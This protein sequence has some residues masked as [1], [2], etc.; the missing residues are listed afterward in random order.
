VDKPFVVI[1]C[2]AYPET[3]LESELFGHEKG[4]FTGANR[5][6]IGRFEQ[7][8]SGTVFLD[9]VGE[10]SLSA[11]VKLLRVLQTQELERLGGEQTIKVD[12]RIL[13]A[14]NKELLEEVNNGNFREDL[15]YRLNVIPIQLPPLR[16]RR[17]DIPLLARHFQRKFASEHGEAEK[18]FNPEVMYRLLNYHWAGNVRELENA[19][20]HAVVLSKDGHIDLSHLPF[21]LFDVDVSTLPSETT[22]SSVARTIVDTEKKLLI[23]VLEECKW[24]KT[25]AAQQLGISRSTLYD[26]IKKYQI[27][28]T[29]I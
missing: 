3:L 10:I 26:K 8:D 15:Y 9:E 24:N 19:I 20:E 18:D 2:S 23:D 17:N 29:D 14:T 5:Q 25:K 11:Q 13:A 28:K 1:N 16:Q 7:A 12:V 27:V 4:A 6:K 21:D 22:N